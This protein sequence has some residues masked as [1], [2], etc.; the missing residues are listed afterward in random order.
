MAESSIATTVASSKRPR[1]DDI[2]AG[3]TTQAKKRRNAA[4]ELVRDEDFWYE[5]GTIILV[6]RNVQFRVYRG[7][8]ADHSSVF[9]N[10]FSFSTQPTSPPP[11]AAPA[12][13][14]VVHLDDS[15]EDLR[16]ILRALLPKKSAFVELEGPTFYEISA[17]VR[18][19]NK[20]QIDA[21]LNHSLSYLKRCFP[22]DFDARQEWL[23]DNYGQVP[24][25]WGDRDAMVFAIGVVNLSRLAQVDTILP[26]ALAVCCC[27]TAK[28]LVA[29]FNREDG[30][31]E[32][33]SEED[34]IRCIAGM[35]QLTYEASAAVVAAFARFS[36]RACKAGTACQNAIQELLRDY[37]EEAPY[38]PVDNP[39]RDWEGWITEYWKESV[40][41][42]CRVE[43][44]ERFRAQQ[45]K[46]W[47][48]LPQIFDLTV[49]GWPR[50]EED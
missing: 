17:Y 30:S 49:D 40:C 36:P 34:L 46:M 39:F 28:Q 44:R 38:F 33:L 32:R 10:M 14:P 25:E 6:A 50:E 42:E 37:A 15:P 9:A 27:L 3:T 18:L 5:D 45:R 4:V 12:D 41:H 19:G 24:V 21:L 31:P 22:T 2:Q 47:A 35:R 16:H 26:S 48:R 29:G 13:C 1:E 43:V 8:L 20:Y 23:S 7:V 11:N